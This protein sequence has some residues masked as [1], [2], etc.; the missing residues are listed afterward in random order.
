MSDIKVNKTSK[1]NKRNLSP[2]YRIIK[3]ISLLIIVLVVILMILFFTKGIGFNTPPWSDYSGTSILTGATTASGPGILQT[4]TMQ[5]LI[6]FVGG[7]ALGVAGAL[8]QKVTKNRLAEVSILG[9]GSLNIFFVYGYAMFFKEKA[10]GNGPIAIMMPIFL[11]I[12]SIFGT[13]IVWAISRSRNAN[14]NTFVI[15]GIA[16]Q[17][18]VEALSVI[19]V[20]PSKLIHAGTN[21]AGKK[22]WNRIKGYTLGKVRSSVTDIAG[23]ENPVMWWLIITG[24]VIVI[25]VIA[26]IFFLRRKIDTYET[27]E[28]LASSTGINIKWLRLGIYILVALLAGTASAVLGTVALLGIIAPSIARMLFKNKMWPMTIASFLIGGAMVALASFVSMQLDL[29]VSVGILSTAIV[30]PYFIFLMVKE[31]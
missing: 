31:K 2:M 20:N 23:K 21:S 12:V 9:I 10:F 14:K 29:G 13:L 22:V 4:R 16:L 15:V 24:I 8:L 19:I 3:W 28:D 6:T 18:F 26:I 11:I 27:S 5:V 25:V 30:I 1:T 17:L 7:G